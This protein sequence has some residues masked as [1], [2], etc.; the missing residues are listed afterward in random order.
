MLLG[1]EICKQSRDGSDVLCSICRETVN[2]LAELW[3]EKPLQPVGTVIERDAAE[4]ARSARAQKESKRRR[5]AFSIFERA[6]TLPY[7]G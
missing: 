7:A 5:R 1:C 2:R 4:K 6:I 3:Q